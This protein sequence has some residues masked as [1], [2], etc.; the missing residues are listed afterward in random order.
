M[1]IVHLT[2]PFCVARLIKDKHGRAIVQ[3]LNGIKV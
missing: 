2:V 3:Y 1:V